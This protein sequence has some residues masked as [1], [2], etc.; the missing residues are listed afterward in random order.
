MVVLLPDVKWFVVLAAEAEVQE[1][2]EV[3]S[4]CLPV[5]LQTQQLRHLAGFLE[6]PRRDEA[7]DVAVLQ[8]ASLQ[9]ARLGKDVQEAEVVPHNETPA[10]WFTPSFRF[11]LMS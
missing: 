11:M 4:G 1:M 7:K 10:V 8:S 5:A 9:T 3:A 2:A 6:A